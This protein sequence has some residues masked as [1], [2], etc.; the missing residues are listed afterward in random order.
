MQM[1]S[2]F[3]LAEN[4]Q[5]KYSRQLNIGDQ[6][7]EVASIL[8][9]TMEDKN[10]LEGSDFGGKGGGNMRKDLASLNQGVDLESMSSQ[11]SVTEEVYFLACDSVFV[12][13]FAFSE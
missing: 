13:Y 4:V 6:E 12:L 3:N 7:S 1:N 9:I 8:Q 2:D 10:R 5:A 11:F